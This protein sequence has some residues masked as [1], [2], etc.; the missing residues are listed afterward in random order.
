M[1]YCMLVYACAHDTIFDICLF[2]TDLSIQVCLRVYTTWLHFTY[3]LGYFLTTS[4]PAFSDSEA[5]I[6]AD[7]SAKDQLIRAAQ[8]KHSGPSCP[9]CL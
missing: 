3:L 1:P 6:D 5:W 7:P 4:G 2:D 8:Q 9:Y